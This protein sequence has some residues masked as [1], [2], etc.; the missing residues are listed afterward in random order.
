MVRGR[1]ED[2]PGP[3]REAAAREV[4][5]VFSADVGPPGT[6]SDITAT[7]HTAAGCVFLKGI[8]LEGPHSAVRRIEAK[9]QPYLPGIAPR[10]MGQFETAGWLVLLFEHVA[11]RHADFSPG[12]GDLPLVAGVLDELSRTFRPELP[13]LPIER[14]WAAFAEVPALDLLRGETLVHMDLT[15]ENL[16]IG[17]DGVRVV[18]WAWPTRG[19]GWLDTAFF[20]VRLVQAGHRPRDAELWAR[21]VEA[22]RGVCNAHIDAFMGAYAGVGR[23][24][25]G[26]LER[27][28]QYRRG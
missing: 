11:G 20:V 17:D 24:A 26:A 15:Q 22:W 6:G 14:R 27:W 1:W 9:V 21:R 23:H 13:V 25:R 4:G 2:L 12:S 18:D 10:L 5:K 19:A 3:V 28:A 8:R 16:I 7:L